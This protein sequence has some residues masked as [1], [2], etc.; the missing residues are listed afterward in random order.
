MFSARASMFWQTPLTV[1]GIAHLVVHNGCLVRVDQD[2]PDGT[3]R[4]THFL[5]L[6][7]PEA[8]IPQETALKSNSDL[9]HAVKTLHVPETKELKALD[10]VSVL[11]PFW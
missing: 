4:S 11:T 3:V 2:T 9:Y 5:S 1:Y 6:M 8:C 10:S 7:H